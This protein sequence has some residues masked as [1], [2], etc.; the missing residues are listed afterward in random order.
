VTTACDDDDGRSDRE[1]APCRRCHVGTGIQDPQVLVRCLDDV[2]QGDGAFDEIDGRA[3]PAV[4]A[5]AC[6]DVATD[7]R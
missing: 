7:R 1:Q 6:V 3:P 4:T 2:A 5:G